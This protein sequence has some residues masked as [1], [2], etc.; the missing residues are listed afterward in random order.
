[1][2]FNKRIIITGLFL[3]V[4]LMVGLC[5]PVLA[6]TPKQGG[7]LIIGVTIDIVGLDPHKIGVANEPSYY[8]FEGL[9]RRMPDNTF[10]PALATDWEWISDTKIRFKLREGVKFHTGTPFNAE[11]VK[12]NI[13]RYTDP[14]DPGVPYAHVGNLITDVIIEDEY[15]VVIELAYPNA[16]F[17]AMAACEEGL[18]MRDP[19]AVEEFGE[20]F[21][22]H[23]SGTGPFKLKEWIK[24]KYV[25]LERNDDWW[26]KAPY[27]NEIRFDTIRDT[28]TRGM[29]LEAGMIDLFFDPTISQIERFKDDPDYRVVSIAGD[30]IVKLD[31]NYDV[32]IWQNRNMRKAINLAID[33]K[34]ITETMGPLAEPVDS[35]I[36]STN[37]GY[38]PQ[39][40]VNDYDPD[41]ALQLLAEEGWERGTDNFLYKDGN[42]LKVS[43]GVP[44]ARDPR[45]PQTAQMLAEYLRE[46]GIDATINNMEMGIFW[47][48]LNQ[49]ERPHDIF[50]QSW[51]T[52]FL[53]PTHGLYGNYHGENKSPQ[54]LN[55]SRRSGGIVDV[56]MKA[57]FQMARWLEARL[58][59][60]DAIQNI[61]YEEAIAIPLYG[62]NR[63]W[64]MRSE[65]K[66]FVPLPVHNQYLFIDTWLD[67]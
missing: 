42:K 5:L 21:T 50:F 11:V 1:M 60:L 26:G 40:W 62:L 35:M 10:G 17:I 23:P 47:A 52:I 61:F 33:R 28:E 36:T 13:D 8:I 27:L 7:R 58:K 30:R 64:V 15:T 63:T 48:G 57:E 44:G 9:V 41:K 67:R 56:L 31:F 32:P 43:I 65:V 3:V 53:E 39:G 4:F 14:N 51:G 16:V 66:G 55:H 12:W 25:L 45:N 46:I 37:W 2:K 38:F 19:K 20:D 24:R 29:A 54:G 34:A 18:P 22:N 59:V 6:S 49:P